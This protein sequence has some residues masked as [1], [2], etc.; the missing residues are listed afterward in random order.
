[1]LL[2]CSVLYCVVS[3]YILIYCVLLLT[4]FTL[5]Q[6]GDMYGLMLYYGA[7][8]AVYLVIA[9]WYYCGM[10]TFQEGAIPIQ[11]YILGTIV[12]GFLA[13]AFQGIDLL[14]WNITGTRNPPVMYTSKSL[15]K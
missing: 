14:T 11:K 3:Y 13:T 10:K 15:I 6:P 12:L 7:M 4:L 5:S 9:L 8:T 2:C 1:M